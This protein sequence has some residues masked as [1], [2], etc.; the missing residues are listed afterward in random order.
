MVEQGVCLSVALWRLA[1]LGE[2]RVI[3]RLSGIRRNKTTPADVIRRDF[4]SS[5]RPTDGRTPF[6]MLAKLTT[7]TCV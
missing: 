3:L 5:Q 7:L 6:L 2:A 4:A 1:R